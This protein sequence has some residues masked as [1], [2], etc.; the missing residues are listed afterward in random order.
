MIVLGTHAIHF[1]SAESKELRHPTQLP[2]C[3][4][5]CHFS[6]LL[7]GDLLDRK[8]FVGVAIKFHECFNFVD[9]RNAR[10]RLRGG[11]SQVRERIRSLHYSLQIEKAY[12]CWAKAFVLRVAQRRGAAPAGC[13]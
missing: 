7:R 4:T 9:G 12:V 5:K 2:R 6:E 3:R 1:S 10:V 11:R 8:P 13:G